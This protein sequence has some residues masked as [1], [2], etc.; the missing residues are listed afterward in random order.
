MCAHSQI[1]HEPSSRAAD[2][3]G[4]GTAGWVADEGANSA[5]PGVEEVMS[6]AVHIVRETP[7]T[8]SLNTRMRDKN[9]TRQQFVSASNRLVRILIDEALGLFPATPVTIETPCGPYQGCTLP[10]ES[11]ICAV[12]IL[13]AADCMLGEVRNIL[14]SCSVGKILIQ[15]DEATAQPQLIYSKLPPDVARRPVLLCDPSACSSSTCDATILA[16]SAPHV[17]LRPANRCHRPLLTL[18]D[19]PPIACLRA[20]FLTALVTRQCLP[21]VAPP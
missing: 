13:R 5:Q 16:L 1:A 14:P 8:K 12:S 3:D 18:N 20:L 21:P 9:A 7:L 2:A 15:R 6:K 11:S 19:D 10:D 17:A 4:R